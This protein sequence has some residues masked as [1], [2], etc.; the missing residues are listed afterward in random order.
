M[1]GG[2]RSSAEQRLEIHANY[3][4]IQ[5][6]CELCEGVL[7]IGMSLQTETLQQFL[8]KV[9]SMV[10]KGQSNCHILHLYNLIS[11]TMHINTLELKDN[12]YIYTHNHL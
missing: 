11:C 10:S 1:T 5:F 9:F 7:L 2:Y 6:K 3:F 8:Y 12:R 4:F